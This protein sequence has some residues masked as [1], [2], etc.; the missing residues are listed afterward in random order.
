MLWITKESGS[1]A[2]PWGKGDDILRGGDGSDVYLFE[3]DW[4]QDIIDNY[5]ADA[6]NQ[7]I[8]TLQF[9]IGITPSSIFLFHSD[10]DLLII[11]SGQNDSIL[12]KNYFVNDATTSAAIESLQFYDG[13]IWDVAGVKSIIASY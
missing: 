7:Q 8:D 1:V 5:D 6:L 9:G 4:G 12:V 3:F 13:S 10:N 2:R 11:K